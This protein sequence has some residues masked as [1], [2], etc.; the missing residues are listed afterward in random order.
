[1][2]MQ[3]HLILHET[4]EVCPFRFLTLWSE[5]DMESVSSKERV[6]VE[7]ERVFTVGAVVRSEVGSVSK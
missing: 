7:V 1:M 2:K 5:C 6:V 4:L 3:L